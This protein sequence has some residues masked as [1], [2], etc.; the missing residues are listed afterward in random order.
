MRRIHETA[1]SPRQTVPPG[2]A[3]GVRRR[4][5]GSLLALGAGA[6]GVVIA[7]SLLRSLPELSTS[8]SPSSPS[9]GGA[10]AVASP[11][12]GFPVPP[13]GSLVFAAEAGRDALGLAVVSDTRQLRLQASLV[14]E[15]GEGTPNLRVAFLVEGSRGETARASAVACGSGCYRA[16][17][18]L[19]SRP[20]RVVVSIGRKAEERIGFVLPAAWPLRPAAAIVL[21]AARVWR[22]LRTLVFHD[23]LSSGGAVTVHTLWKIVAP[24]R[25]SYRIH[26]GGESIVIGGR[27]WSRFTSAGPWQLTPQ[28]PVRQPLPAWVDVSDAYVL[29]TSSV[30]GKPAWHISFFD[31]ATPGWFSIFVDERSFHTVE[32]HMVAAAHFMRDVYG[33]FDAPLSIVPPAPLGR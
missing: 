12:S 18:A 31:P 30:D 19:S 3:N 9:A 8:P 10:Q 27:R 15:N 33:P 13:A 14:D 28:L 16:A 4:L 21:H 7:L 17:V 6:G 24:D 22:G 5:G 11:T 29:G 26:G 2:S 1:S 25:L 32:I 23:N 20:R